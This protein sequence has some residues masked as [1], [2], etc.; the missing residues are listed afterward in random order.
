MS[1]TPAPV[2]T[3]HS[4]GGGTAGINDDSGDFND[5]TADNS[6]TLDGTAV[7]GSTVTIFDGT[8]ELGTTVTNNAG[9]WK[10]VTG[11]LSDGS[12]D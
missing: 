8:T 1:A 5:V 9:D 6:V 11:P 2:I 7:A 10:Y 4:I 3:S 12:N